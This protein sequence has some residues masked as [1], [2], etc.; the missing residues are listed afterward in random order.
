[1]A[2]KGRRR[3]RQYGMTASQSA[4][5]APVVRS[6]QTARQHMTALALNNRLHRRFHELTDRLLG[7][8]ADDEDHPDYEQQKADWAELVKVREG[9]IKLTKAVGSNWKAIGGHE[10][11]EGLRKVAEALG[12]DALPEADMDE[13]LILMGE[14]FDGR[15]R[16]KEL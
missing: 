13:V 11:D 14:F 4:Q 5:R 9:M 3:D 1:M 7:P 10:V 12:L 15:H 8:Y 2:K 6:G 16:G